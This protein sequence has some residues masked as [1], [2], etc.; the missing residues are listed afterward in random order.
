MDLSLIQSMIP[1]VAKWLHV[2]PATVLLMWMILSTAANITSRLIPDTATG[3][4]GTVRKLC[5]ILGVHV[6]NRVAPPNI[7]TEDVAED[8]LES[9]VTKVALPSQ[10]EDYFKSIEKQLEPDGD[11]NAQ[12]QG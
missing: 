9:G 4:L 3:W 5:A 1:N 6:Q 12:P 7:T 8:V 2:E 10:V 11:S